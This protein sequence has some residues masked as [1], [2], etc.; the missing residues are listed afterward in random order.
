MGLESKHNYSITH[1]K[2]SCPFQFRDIHYRQPG[3]THHHPHRPD[4]AAADSP[5]GLVKSEE[6]TGEAAGDEAVGEA[7]RPAVSGQQLEFAQ[8]SRSG[9]TLNIEHNLMI[10]STSEY[11]IT[12]LIAPDNL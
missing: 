3:N 11:H 2:L 1:Y 9:K 5:L 6:D 8:E 10:R 4:R 7:H 12:C